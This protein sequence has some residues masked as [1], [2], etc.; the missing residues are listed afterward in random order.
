MDDALRA[1]RAAI[2]EG[3]IP[4][5]GVASVSYTHLDVYKRQEQASSMTHMIFSLSGS[6]RLN[7]NRAYSES[8]VRCV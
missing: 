6:G 5:G 4:G 8:G 7:A 1:T 3:I 2:E